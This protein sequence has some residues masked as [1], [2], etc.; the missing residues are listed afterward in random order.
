[1]VFL[2]V[3]SQGRHCHFPARILEADLPVGI[4]LI[5]GYEINE[6]KENPHVFSSSRVRGSQAPERQQ[7]VLKC[8]LISDRKL[9]FKNFQETGKR[10]RSGSVQLAARITGGVR[11][12]KR[13]KLPAEYIIYIRVQ[14]PHSLKKTP[15]VH[16][17]ID[18]FLTQSS[19]GY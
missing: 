2:V 4:A 6:T 17:Y 5:T 7:H 16:L 19:R 11:N 8:F 12:R 14:E 3:K 1:M 13:T 15:P 18:A 9:P 10:K